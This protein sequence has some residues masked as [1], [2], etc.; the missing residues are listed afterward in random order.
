[1]CSMVELFGIKMSKC[2][3]DPRFDVNVSSIEFNEA[4]SLATVT[5]TSSVLALNL[6]SIPNLL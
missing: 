2:T 3:Q 1:M 6:S 4:I 5:F